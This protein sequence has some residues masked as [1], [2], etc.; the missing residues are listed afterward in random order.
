MKSCGERRNVPLLP[1]NVKQLEFRGTKTSRAYYGGMFWFLVCC[2]LFLV[3][4]GVWIFVATES[5]THA[6]GVIFL[7]LAAG[8]L[9]SLPGMFLQAY[10]PR[11]LIAGSRIQLIKFVRLCDYDVSEIKRYKVDTIGSSTAGPAV[12]GAPYVEARRILFYGDH[13]RVLGVA[14]LPIER[15]D[16]LLKWLQDTVP[17][18]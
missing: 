11:V 5:D 13:D 2:E 6:M 4:L 8:T 16:V 9:L 3:A 1:A 15:P 17:G 7:L 18:S 12:T 14:V 10:R